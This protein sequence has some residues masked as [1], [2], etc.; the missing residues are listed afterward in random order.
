VLA[1][2]VVA[3]AASADTPPITQRSTGKTFHL[4][5]GETA[6]LRLSNRW[7]WTDPFVSTKA[8]VL[9]PVEYFV[10]PGFREWKID[11]RKVGRA[12]IRSVGKPGC[13]ACALATRSFR[14]TVVVG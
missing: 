1:F 4:G 9:T 3:G 11:A 6:T 5:K 10:D 13:S 2:I 7:R 12:T 8:V 14:V